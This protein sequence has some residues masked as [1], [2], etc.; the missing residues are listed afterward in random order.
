MSV[1]AYGTKSQTSPGM[2]HENINK[3]PNNA[4]K[5]QTDCL[6]ARKKPNFICGISIPLS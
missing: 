1:Q 6:K 2:P 3:K 4:K 5:G